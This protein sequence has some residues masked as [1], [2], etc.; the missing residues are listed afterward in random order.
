MIFCNLA[1]SMYSPRVHD[2]F[3]VFHQPPLA[4]KASF[5]NIGHRMTFHVLSQCSLLQSYPRAFC[6]LIHTST[7]RGSLIP[8]IS[9]MTVWEGSYFRRCDTLPENRLG[10]CMAHSPQT[11]P[12]SMEW[13]HRLGLCSS[14]VQ[15][16]RKL[17]LP[18]HWFSAK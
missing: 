15:S 17:S 2:N 3:L 6:I 4:C 18:V 1:F 11:T 9:H 10:N 7:C 16:S 13:L 12:T 14:V 8:R 5:Y